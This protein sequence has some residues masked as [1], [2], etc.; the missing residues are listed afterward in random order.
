VDILASDHAPHSIE[1]KTQTNAWQAASGV[2]GLETSLPLM[3]TQVS[4]GKLSLRRLIEATSTLPAK[5][6]HL[7]RKGALKVGFDA[8]LVLVDPKAKSRI[9]PQN[10]LSKA[11]YTPFEGV[12][13]TGRAV[14]TFVN[15]TL[16]AEK[17]K[18][19]GPPAGR[20]TKS[21]STCASS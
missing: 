15:G 17:G 10:F 14:Y 12:R 18:I 3:F 20:V 4:Q 11:K 6:F 13:C 2:P 9:N 5:I 7:T 19:V 21:D 16:V 1:E 8:D